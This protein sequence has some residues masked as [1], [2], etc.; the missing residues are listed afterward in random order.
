MAVDFVRSLLGYVGS[1]PNTADGSS[2]Q[3][4]AIAEGIL[5][6]LGV[7]HQAPGKQPGGTALENGVADFL[8]F[9]L[10]VADP[11]RPW[12]V[13]RG[14]KI[15]DFQQYAHLG[16]LD[17]LV[18]NDTSDLLRVEIGQDYM[19]TPDVTVGLGVSKPP[20]LH[21]AVSCKFSI[22][23]DRVQNIRHEGIGLIRHRRGR[24]PHI[25]TVTSE[26]LPSRL[27]AI[28]RGTG[29]V[30]AVYH[31]CLPELREVVEAVG[32]TE[33]RSA[34]AEAV[35]QRRLFDLAD[36]VAHLVV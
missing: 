34:L 17:R 5:S 21:A 9:A 19:I 14:G 18:Q 4:F 8:G 26:P 35:G 33:Q 23:S 31:V 29:E 12:S 7:S 13:R 30:D 16:D 3:S 6:L 27:A 36:L 11:T 25:V 22:R 24:Q 1:K 10:P 2:K 15:S 28:C 32:N 20:I